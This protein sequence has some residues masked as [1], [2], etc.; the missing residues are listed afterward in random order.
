MIENINRIVTSGTPRII[1][2]KMVEKP[3]T[4]GREERRPRVKTT[5][6]GKLL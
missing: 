3:L 1:S 6:R 4:T 5:P 2:I